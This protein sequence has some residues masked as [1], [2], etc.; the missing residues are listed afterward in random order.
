[1][2]NYENLKSAIKQVIKANGN[3]EI[4]GELLQ[5]T[6]LAMLNSLGA[7]YQFAGVAE[8]DMD[9]GEPDQN[10]FYVATAGNYP[11]FGGISVYEGELALLCY[12]GTWAKKKAFK[13]NVFIARYGEPAWDLITDALAEGREVVCF[14]EN[15]RN[16][17]SIGTLNNFGEQQAIFTTVDKDGVFQ[18]SCND[19]DKWVAEAKLLQ[20]H[21]RAGINIKNV[22]GNSLVG[23]GNIEIEIPIFVAVYG[24]TT[25]EEIDLAAINGYAIFCVKNP[26]N[27]SE[28]AMMAHRDE[29]VIR[30]VSTEADGYFSAY[31]I[32][33]ANDNWVEYLIPV[34]AKLVSG[35]NIK[36][37]N[38]ESLL[39]GGNLSIMP[40]LVDIS[41]I[42]F[43]ERLMDNQI[44]LIVNATGVVR[45]D[46]VYPRISPRD[47]GARQEYAEQYITSVWSAFGSIESEIVDGAPANIVGMSAIVLCYSQEK[48]G[49][50]LLDFEI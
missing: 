45:S 11:N 2:A 13:S 30:F 49:W 10:V 6:L 1:M 41:G 24:K 25:F 39:G 18:M 44:Y 23:A 31:E 37:I 47:I 43:G 36:T 27:P 17:I 32:Y 22:N 3:G 38:G 35:S 26:N 4:T 12:N 28:I 9:P 15:E 50:I 14:W 42:S 16:E 40:G 5:Q 21:L 46:G 19:E 48:Q 33:S 8:P 29:M 34:Q 20:E 7:N